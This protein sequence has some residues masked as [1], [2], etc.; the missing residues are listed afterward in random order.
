M[1]LLHSPPR[2]GMMPAMTRLYDLAALRHPT[3]RECAYQA[4]WIAT[5]SEAATGM[6][7]PLVD[8]PPQ[9]RDP[10]PKRDVTGVRAS[11]GRIDRFRRLIGR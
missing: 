6:G 3:L 9:E 10:G 2:T 5:V 7:D 8:V 4:A 1:I 11:E